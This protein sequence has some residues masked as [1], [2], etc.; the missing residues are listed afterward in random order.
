[1]DR[2]PLEI[3]ERICSNFCLH[4]RTRS[5]WMPAQESIID[6]HMHKSSLANFS[7]TCSWIRTIVQPML[8]HYFA[9]QNARDFNPDALPA[10]FKLARFLRTTPSSA[11]IWPSACVRKGTWDMSLVTVLNEASRRLKLCSGSENI[12]PSAIPD[13]QDGS[14]FSIRMGH[15]L[16]E[17]ALLLLPSVSHALITRHGPKTQFTWLQRHTDQFRRQGLKGLTSLKKVVI[18]SPHGSHLKDSWYITHAASLIEAA[19]NLEE[20]SALDCSYPYLKPA[21]NLSHPSPAVNLRILTIQNLLLDDLNS[22]LSSFPRLQELYY[23]QSDIFRP[24]S[25]SSSSDDYITPRPTRQRCKEPSSAISPVAS[26]LRILQLTFRTQTAVYP[27]FGAD[28]CLSLLS[29]GY[30][31]VGG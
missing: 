24:S 30:G 3:I 11:R 26:T 22:L 15:R 9:L 13:W 16:Q 20:L 28:V 10:I 12:I 7:A 29:E 4:C 31:A 5:E 27:G 17:L 14:P 25:S 18:A 1:M 6:H 8:F 19:P 2:V 21:S 23:R